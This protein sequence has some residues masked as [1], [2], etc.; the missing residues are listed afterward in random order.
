MI[1][2]GSSPGDRRVIIAAPGEL[3]SGE[4][5]VL[6]RRHDEVVLDTLLR[7][8]WTAPYVCRR[9][10]CGVCLIR[11]HRGEVR[12]GPHTERA[13]SRRAETEERLGLACRAIPVTSVVEIGFCRG[14]AER[15]TPVSDFTRSKARE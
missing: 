1:P 5:N 12:H 15:Q 4:R 6:I 10:G 14:D 3:V 9:G 2:Q 13:L 8:G 7:L 11:L